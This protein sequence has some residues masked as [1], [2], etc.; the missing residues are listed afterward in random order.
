VG[1][2]FRCSERVKL[3]A[4][5]AYDESPVPDRFRTARS[6]GESRFWVAGGVQY[7]PTP[8]S[9]IDGSATSTSCSAVGRWR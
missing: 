4:G 9:S 5:V 3:R 7:K 1:L 2:N 6:P 8:S